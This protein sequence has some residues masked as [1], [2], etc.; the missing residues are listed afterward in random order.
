MSISSSIS[1]KEILQV[2]TTKSLLL[3]VGL[4]NWMS[5]NG[6]DSATPASRGLKDVEDAAAHTPV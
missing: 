5:K 4:I 6:R 2:R 3:V 1:S